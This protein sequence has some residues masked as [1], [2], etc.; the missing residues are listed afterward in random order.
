[1]EHYDGAIIRFGNNE[2][3]CIR[4]K[5]HISL[6]NELVCDSAYWFEGQKHNLLS[7]A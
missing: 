2:P 6:A 7:V 4:G 3:S 1:M 5:S